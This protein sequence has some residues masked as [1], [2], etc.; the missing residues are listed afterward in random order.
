MT[1]A[2]V[3]LSCLW[4]TTLQFLTHALNLPRCARNRHIDT[5]PASKQS[6]LRRRAG[7]PTMLVTASLA[8]IV[9]RTR[10]SSCFWLEL[11]ATTCAAL[12]G[13]ASS[14]TYMIWWSFFFSHAA[15]ASKQPNS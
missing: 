8:S 3:L 10:M 14:C 2:A 6:T 11:Y 15:I 1:A 13:V 7:A 9:P 5:K 12:F 4:Q